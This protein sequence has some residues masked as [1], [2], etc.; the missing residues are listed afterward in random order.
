[1]CLLIV[2]VADVLIHKA[3]EMPFIYSDYMVE[4][5]AAAAADPALSST[6][7][8]RT[9]EARPLRLDIEALDRFDHFGVEVCAAIK[10]QVA[11]SRVEGE[12][13]AQLLNDPGTGRMCGYVAIGRYAAD[14]AQ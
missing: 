10:D 13:L 4:Q 8:P 1:M 14:H 11:G 5:V 9:S 7:L 3:L 6:V 12:C 2:V